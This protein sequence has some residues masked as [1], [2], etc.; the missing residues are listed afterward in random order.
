MTAHTLPFFTGNESTPT[1][2]FTKISTKEPNKTGV[3]GKADKG[4]QGA[5]RILRV[6][7]HN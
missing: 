4:R 3:W 7:N 6:L 2:P 1:R 5:E